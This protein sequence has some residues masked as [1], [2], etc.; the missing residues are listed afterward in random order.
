MM[1][2]PLYGYDWTLPYVSEVLLLGVNSRRK[3]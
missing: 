2:I 1:G 3:H